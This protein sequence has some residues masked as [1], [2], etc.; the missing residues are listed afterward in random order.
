MSDSESLKVERISST[1]RERTLEK[2]RDA[3]ATLHFKPGQRLVERDLCEQLAVS[4]T[5]VREV[6]R[7]LEAEGLVENAPNRG[8]VVAHVS[9]DQAG[10]IYEIRG[11][12]EGSAARVCALTAT[13]DLIKRL[14]AT[15]KTIRDSYA[16]QSPVKVLA[17]TTTFYQILFRHSKHDIAGRIVSSLHGRINFLRAVTIA[18]PRRDRDAP[19]EMALI[20]D[21][22]ERR[23]P[24]AAVQACVAHV[25]NAAAL[26]QAALVEYYREAEKELPRPSL[27]K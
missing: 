13:P 26:A 12:L 21:A 27:R 2:M 24:D 10:Q 5:V 18:T 3:F 22:I 6:L 17:A 19:K 23:D 15:L 11:Q 1:L 25:N 14:K 4:R 7:Q 20:I 8:P 16:L 9:P